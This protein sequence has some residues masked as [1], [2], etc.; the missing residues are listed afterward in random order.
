MAIPDYQ[1]IMFP[2]LQLAGDGKEHLFRDTVTKLADQFALT[3][4]ER[5]QPLPSRTQP[6]FINRVGWART[7]LVKSGLLSRRAVAIFASLTGVAAC[8]AAVTA[9]CP[10]SKHLP[11]FRDFV[12]P[13]GHRTGRN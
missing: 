1:T 5:A 12:A 3:A 9:R 7:Y 10:G 8:S 6:L 4:E 11:R 13:R 2:L